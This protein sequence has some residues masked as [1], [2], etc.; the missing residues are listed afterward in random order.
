[1]RKSLRLPA[2]LQTSLPSIE[3]IDRELAGDTPPQPGDEP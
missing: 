2:A 3:Q 1:M